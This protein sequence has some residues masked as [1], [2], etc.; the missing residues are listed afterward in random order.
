MLRNLIDERKYRKK[1]NAL[2][3]V[4][5]ETLIERDVLI[6]ENEVLRK[7]VTRLIKERNGI[8]GR[9]TKQKISNNKGLNGNNGNRKTSSTKDNGRS[10][11]GSKTKTLPIAAN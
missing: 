5:E 9:N 11:M 1:Y 7:E 10:N 6:R 4:H 8:S 2:K 3:I